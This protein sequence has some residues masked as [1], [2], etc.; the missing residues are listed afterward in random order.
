MDLKMSS[1]RMFVLHAIS[2]PIAFACF[3]T[4]TEDMVNLWHCKYGQLNFKGSTTL[5]QRHIVNGLP[6]FKPPLRLWT[7]YL[8]RKQLRDS[9]P[10]KS[11][12]SAR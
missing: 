9:F 3:N 8:A 4:I 10:K 6:Q 7:D 1:N 11:T 5:Q 12:W 2:Q